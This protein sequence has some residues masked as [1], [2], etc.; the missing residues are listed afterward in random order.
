MKLLTS[1]PAIYLNVSINDSITDFFKESV[2]KY[3]RI[4]Y[5]AIVNRPVMNSIWTFLGVIIDDSV[6]VLYENA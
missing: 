4:Q 2:T 1:E 5:K 3:Q 6:K